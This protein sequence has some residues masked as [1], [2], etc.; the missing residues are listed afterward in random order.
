MAI[1]LPREV[2]EVDLPTGWVGA[3]SS[4]RDCWCVRCQGDES[5]DRRTCILMALIE[6]MVLAERSF[7]SLMNKSASKTVVA[8]EP[9][10]ES[11]S[12][13]KVSWSVCAPQPCLARSTRRPR[14]T[15]LSSW[16]SNATTTPPPTLL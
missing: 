1:S 14:S 15:S 4:D 6:S 16:L 5:S 10:V 2:V 11:Q 9:T 12:L 3:L 7:T 8:S 13:G